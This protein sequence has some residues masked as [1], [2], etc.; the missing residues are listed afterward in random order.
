MALAS[1]THV[2]VHKVMGIGHRERSGCGHRVGLFLA[3]LGLSMAFPGCSGVSG[4]ADDGLGGSSGDDPKETA[5]ELSGTGEM[6]ART[7]SGGKTGSGSKN[8]DAGGESF[9]DGDGDP[10]PCV[11]G[12]RRCVED[13]PEECEDGAWIADEPCSGNTPACSNGVCAAARLSG[14]LVTVQSLLPSGSVR[15][16]DHGFLT[17]PRTCSEIDGET[18]CLIGGFRP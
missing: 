5:D 4:K 7:G 14:S 6:E 9:G 13:I 8:G 10:D 12:R 16:R 3:G 1:R 2:Y 18:L 17:L 15:L 11:D